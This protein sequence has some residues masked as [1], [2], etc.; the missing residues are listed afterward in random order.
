MSPQ[1][2]PTLRRR[3][4]FFTLL[5][6]LGLATL[7]FL[8]GAA[9]MFFQLPPSAY[10]SKSFVGAR[11]WAGRHG[12]NAVPEVDDAMG[13]TDIVDDPNK[14][15][16]GFTLFTISSNSISS[17]QAFLINMKREV[18]YRWAVSFSD[19][20]HNPPQLDGQQV[21][22]SDV[23]IFAWYLYPNGNLLVV[24]QSTEYYPMGCGLAMLD[25]D[26]HVL[27]KYAA[28]VHHDVDVGEDG[29]IYS[30]VQTPVAHPPQELAGRPAPWLVDHVVMLSPDGKELTAPISAPRRD[31]AAPL[32]LCTD[33]RFARK[34]AR[35]KH[36]R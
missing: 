16:D 29:T 30:L 17:T 33:A 20:W 25:K 22:D 10:L 11:A 8:L 36:S 14:T 27:W 6:I 15:S 23:C 13:F 2:P 19:I 18:V 3:R 21:K 32:P 34:T 28:R 12:T 7:C 5:P 24:F 1:T 35:G 4:F 26:S 31:C 9:V